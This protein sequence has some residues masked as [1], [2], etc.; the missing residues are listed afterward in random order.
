[1]L[2]F[3]IFIPKAEN[4]SVTVRRT[5]GLEGGLACVTF[6]LRL[7]VASLTAAAGT[8]WRE[9]GRHKWAIDLTETEA[10]KTDLQKPPGYSEQH[11]QDA[12]EK[13]VASRKVDQM[14]LKLKVRASCWL[15]L[16]LR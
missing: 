11:A 16:L 9:M 13:I 3:E 15:L 5:H 6:S 2:S 7:N 4:E 12:D 14:Q 1:M 10:T 8:A